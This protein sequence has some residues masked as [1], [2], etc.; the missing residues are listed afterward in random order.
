[1]FRVLILGIILIQGFFSTWVYAGVAVIGNN[2]LK[3][4]GK[5]DMNVLSL[6]Y[7]GRS[8]QVEGIA[9]QPVNMKPG[10]ITRS[11]FLKTVLQKSDDDYVA[12]WIVRRAIGKGA[13]PLEMHDPEGMINFIQSNPGAIGYIDDKELVPGV[14]VLMTIP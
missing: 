1:M 6:I 12:Y 9:V 14:C 4:V 3:G 5:I 11:V 10:N 2:S 8:T 7:T 13:P